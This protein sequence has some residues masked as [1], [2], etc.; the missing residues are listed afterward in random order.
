MLTI[1]GK[2]GKCPCHQGLQ[3]KWLQHLRTQGASFRFAALISVGRTCPRFEAGSSIRR[4]KAREPGSNQSGLRRRLQGCGK[5][6][7]HR[8]SHV[9]GAVA[10]VSRSLRRRGPCS[11]SLFFGGVGQFESRKKGLG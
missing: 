8:H 9:T 7:D 11:F 6:G 3:P 2:R 5:A 1:G 4:T 10:A